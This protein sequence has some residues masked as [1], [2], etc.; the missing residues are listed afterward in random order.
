MPP[1]HKDLVK[2]FSPLELT[3]MFD[4]KTSPLIMTPL[5]QGTLGGSTV[6]LQFHVEWGRFIAINVFLFKN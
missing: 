3:D 2:V 5:V 4:G 1:P 6:T